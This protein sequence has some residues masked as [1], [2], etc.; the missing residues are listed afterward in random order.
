MSRL[1]LL[2][3]RSIRV[4]RGARLFLGLLALFVAATAARAQF[5]EPLVFSSGGAVMVRDDATGA[6]TPTTGSPFP[7]SNN[8]LTIDVQGRYLFG[9][10][11]NSIHMYAITDS[12]TGAYQE[13][14]NS[15]FASANT[16][17]PTFIAVEP[18]GSYIAVVNSQSTT[19]GQASAETF[20]ISPSAAGGP[21][22]IPVPGS[23][24]LLDS[25]VIGVSQPAAS[26]K[27]FEIYLGPTFTT[28]PN[29]QH[30][31][32]LDSVSIDPTTG[33]LLGISSE[34]FD[35]STARCYASDPQGRYI[36]TGHGEFEGLIELTGIDGKFP[37]A[38]IMLPEDTFPDSIWVDSTGTFLYAIVGPGGE[39]PVNIYALNLQTNTL[40][41]TASSPLPNATFVPSY[42]PDPTGAFNY[43][44]PCPTPNSLSAFTVD[45]QTGYFV[46]T[47][48]SPFTIPGIGAL[49]FSVVP[50]Q[51]AV[52]GP[53]LQL[54]PTALSLG[55][56]QIGSRSVPQ[57]IMIKSNGAEALSVNSIAVSG[58]DASE[59]LES[60]TCQAPAVLQPNNFC[61]VSITFLPASTGQQTATVNVT[62]NA[63]GS[64]QSVPL[65]G[66][67]VAPPPPA[68]A[69]TIAPNPAIFSSTTQGTTGG[70]ISITVT[71][72]GNATL[73]ISSLLIGGSNPADFTSP[74]SN[75]SGAV[76]AANA[77]CAISVTFAPLA[78]GQRTETITLTDDAANSPQIISVQGS[79]I[80]G[81]APAI[82]IAP[83]PVIFVATTQGTTSG[84]T[85]VAVTN[86]GNATLHISSVAAGGSNPA[87]FTGPARNCSGAAL[88]A[89]ASCTVSVTFAPLTAG[90]RSE[91]ITLTDNAAKSPQVIM[92][93]G[94]A[95]PAISITPISSSSTTATVTPG[96][97]AQY[98]LQITPGANY[99]GT[100]A[101][102]CA[103]APLAAACQIPST[104]QVSSG[105]PAMF[106]VMITTTGT[107]LLAPRIPRGTWRTP[108]F[109]PLR[110]FY[111]P[112][113]LLLWLILLS[114]LWTGRR[115]Y[116]PAVADR[117]LF[118]ERFV[119][120]GVFLAATVAAVVGGCGGGSSSSTSVSQ[121]VQ[122]I[123]TPVGTSIITITP[124]A[125]SASG[126]A[127]QLPPVQLTLI[128]N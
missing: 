72:S 106:S 84:A 62:D 66:A 85:S 7:A 40:T 1:C 97:T 56:P 113:T 115:V 33:L 100:V 17:S 79:A 82:T 71:N 122:T 69:V 36:V 4:F 6:L 12:G 46:P 74:K 30:G 22:L 16:N 78:A 54:A 120:T 87:D 127:L 3:L 91:T 70:T 81:P 48:N 8:T 96:V 19:P 18:T 34:N 39:G 41:E 29:F 99:S 64:P 110:L 121:P 63:P 126:Q 55:T 38:N 109:A 50:G 15:P 24:T 52:S 111:F 125:K 27:A 23:Y 76:L 89:N 47:A 51:Q 119:L 128:V 86:S 2:Q 59:F 20:Q 21:A 68:P 124:S 28:I 116:D 35:T 108:R 10:G 101:L 102:L 80:A 14:E 57:T 75:C 105:T 60:D 45:P 95:N 9:I 53:S 49:T 77:S 92:L 43:G 65:N 118:R 114:A 11:V 26:A 61:S 98:Q 37:G 13:V 123:T 94:N 83:N 104:V 73:H 107:G 93:Q 58:A 31:E 117:A 88:D 44:C 103:G 25:E 112:G 5:Q 32:E 90:Q 67:G 42:Q